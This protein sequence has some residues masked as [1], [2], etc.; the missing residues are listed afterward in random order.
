MSTAIQ[1]MP[2]ITATEEI[3]KQFPALDRLHNGHKVAY[4]DGAGGTQTPRV[5]V[6]AVADYLLNHNANTH[7]EYPTSHETDAIIES[8]RHAFADFLN[9]SANEI[10]FGPNTTTM[11]YHLSRA[12]GRTLGPGDEIVITELE[13]HANVAPWQALV[14]E[15]GVTLNVAQM[16]PET[17]QFDWNDF[18]RLV[19]R[20]TK[21]VAFGAGCNALGTVNDYHRAVQLAHSVGALVLV[22][23][24]HYAPYFLC[25]VKEM[26]CDFLTCSAYK[27]YGPHVSVFYGKKDLL[28][29]IDFP[30]LEP[31]PNTA[32]E[33][34]E[35]GTQI[36]EGIAGAAAAVDFYASLASS[37]GV[38]PVSANSRDAPAAGGTGVSPV[39]AHAQDAPATTRRDSLQSAF[40]GLQ[41]HSS[42][43]VKRLWEDLSHIK[44]V[45]LYG[46]PPDVERTPTVSFVVDGVSSTDVA[47]RL[48][49]RG[50]FASHGDFY[51]A[52]VIKRLGLA[53]EGLVRVGCACYTND[54]EIE[55]L[56]LTVR[57][58]ALGS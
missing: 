53:P 1:H 56:I 20:K 10:V 55:R 28:E 21:V 6:D 42:S 57:D 11:I 5:V 22:D 41:A 46:P 9:A 38:S 14:V 35:M 36:H 40:S 8:A 25:D 34:V 49:E 12:L 54:E 27:F 3:R 52:T 31:A 7:W 43:L 16:D 30:K 32:P 13:H 29:S 23:A 26:N 4:F 51:A 19:S 44:G 17:G 2:S 24:V 39:R 18:E 48:A 37:T 50:L 47:R 58:I 15:R 45:R 33:R